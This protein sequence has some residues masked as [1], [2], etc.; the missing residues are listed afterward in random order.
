MYVCI[1]IYKYIYIY[2]YKHVCVCIY[3]YIYTH[4]H[5]CITYTNVESGRLLLPCH[6]HHE[7]LRGHQGASD[8]HSMGMSKL[9]I[10]HA[11]LDFGLDISAPRFEAHQNHCS[12]SELNS[13]SQGSQHKQP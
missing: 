2:I 5:V 1:Y 10:V 12:Q 7:H 3:I 4:R 11:L 13:E 6:Q 8:L 9:V